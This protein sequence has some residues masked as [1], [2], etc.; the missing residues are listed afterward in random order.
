MDDMQAYSIFFTQ[1]HG[2]NSIRSSTEILA[3]QFIHC[4]VLKSSVGAKDGCNIR[5]STSTL[6]K[7]PESFH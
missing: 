5:S 7:A 3:F 1:Q 4:R 6:Q 2:S